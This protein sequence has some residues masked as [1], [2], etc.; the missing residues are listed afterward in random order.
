[1]RFLLGLCAA[2]V[3]AACSGASSSELFEDGRP[4]IV[5]DDA[6][7]TEP[8][9]EPE[10][11]PEAEPAAREPASEDDAASP[12][13]AGADIVVVV[14]DASPDADAGA[15]HCNR[16]SDCT[17]GLLCNWKTDRCAAPAAI[18]GACKRDVECSDGLCNWKLETCSTPAPSGTGCRRNKEC[19]SGACG[20]S[21]T[22]K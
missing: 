20:S 17:G 10:P 14:N 8:P 22:C 12:K 11:E 19:A 15:A 7:P 1:M 13:D 9:V 18:G 3:V 6:S 16:D 4:A 2:T 5:W 21:S